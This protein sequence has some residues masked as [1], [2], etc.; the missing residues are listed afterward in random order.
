M[1]KVWGYKRLICPNCDPG[2]KNSI[3]KAIY[4]VYYT[5]SS[6]ILVC[7]KCGHKMFIDKKNKGNEI[8]AKR[9]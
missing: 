4:K 5:N 1:E 2:N 3:R 8:I 9:K 6:I 7:R